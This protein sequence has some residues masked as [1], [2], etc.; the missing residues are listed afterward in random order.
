MFSA[1]V[2]F[3]TTAAADTILFK[4]GTRIDIPQTWEEDGQIKYRLYG[5]T[6]S[7]PKEHVLRIVKPSGSTPSGSLPQADSAAQTTDELIIQCRDALARE[8]NNAALQKKLDLLLYHRKAREFADREL[9]QDAI[10]FEKQAY[11]CD[12]D[13]QMLRDS[14]AALYNSYGVALRTKGSLH[15]ALDSFTS[16]L[17]YAP[18]EP[19][20]K[21]NIAV[22]YV[23]FAQSALTK[24]DHLSCRGFLEKAAAF[25]P[26]NPHAFLLSG[27]MEYNQNN[28]DR[29][30]SD[31]SRA[32]QIDPA[33][34][35]A[36]RLLRKLKK[37]R[38]VEDGFRVRETFSFS[39]KFEGAANQELADAVLDILRDA[40]RDMGRDLD[41]YP[42]T[43]VPVII[44][45]PGSLQQLDYFP[46]WAAGTY[47]GKIRISE[48]LWRQRLSIKA[49]LYHEY[50]HV[51]VRIL[52]G[53]NVPFWLNEG[54]AE[55][56]ARQFKHQS[57]NS[58]RARLLSGASRLLPLAEM[59]DIGMA[60][61]SGLSP[62]TRELMYA[63]AESFVL[64]LVEKHSL[65]DLR[66]IL[67]RLA[68]G[69]SMH[70][71][72]REVLLEDIDVLEQHWRSQFNKT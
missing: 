57:M 1:A 44:Y 55:Y 65:R 48:S 9:W 49:V 30:Q 53:Y 23:D 41:V 19:Q 47:D 67:V 42:D 12:P 11:R 29:A 50:T 13:Q 54:L 17:E 26:D 24:S 45:P 37:E 64:Y 66:E 43:A 8:P 5:E 28:Y 20:I 27:I 61:L 21:K 6:V 36:E 3:S 68:R 69:E 35:E 38:A 18:H 15:E 7:C 60:A 10:A 31:W 51:L 16:A 2:F 25:D 59:T 33:L 52:A 56:A 70:Q 14:L 4:N 32:L 46:D 71:A 63:Q 72:A 58:S 39:I 40:Y 34:H 22:M 62:E